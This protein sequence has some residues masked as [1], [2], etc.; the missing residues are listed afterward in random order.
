M[1]Y[2][3]FSSTAPAMPKPAKGTEIVKLLLYSHRYQKTCLNPW[4]R[5]FS[6][7]LA[8]T[9]VA[10]NFNIRTTVGRIGGAFH[11]CRRR[12]STARGGL[13]A[14]RTATSSL[15]A[16]LGS[17]S[18][19]VPVALSIICPLTRSNPALLRD[20]AGLSSAGVKIYQ[21]RMRSAGLR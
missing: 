17:G 21:M 13:W 15:A 12:I 4:F 14:S 16:R 20:K 11:A 18:R 7:S 5:C 1:T 6:L 19:R 8:H 2:N 9:S 3:I 10:Q